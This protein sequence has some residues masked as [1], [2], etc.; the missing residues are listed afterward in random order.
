MQSIC[1]FLNIQISKN[2]SAYSHDS[3][4]LYDICQKYIEN[5]RNLAQ[6][7]KSIL[8]SLLLFFVIV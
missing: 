3:K 6:R 8:L 2:R 5:D 1:V 4:L 7:G